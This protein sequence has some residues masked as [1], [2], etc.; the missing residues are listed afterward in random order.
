MNF[1]IWILFLEIL[2]LKDGIQWKRGC[3]NSLSNQI[4]E[5][6]GAQVETLQLSICRLL[7][8]LKWN[9][10]DKSKQNVWNRSKR[11]H[12]RTT[13]SRGPEGCQTGGRGTWFV[14]YCCIRQYTCL[15]KMPVAI[16]RWSIFVLSR[17]S[18]LSF[19]IDVLSSSFKFIIDSDSSTVGD[20][21]TFP[22]CK[23]Y[24]WPGVFVFP[25]T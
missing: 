3:N 9:L 21:L 13:N 4:E 18:S 15:V 10:K 20:F 8:H 12:H 1:L 11:C 23:H 7:E 25:A 19:P 2:G 6:F 5:C 24:F 17:L 14:N 22:K 16:I